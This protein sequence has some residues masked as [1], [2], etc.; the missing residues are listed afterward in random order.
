LVQAL[1]K[2][3]NF[4]KESSERGKSARDFIRYLDEMRKSGS[5]SEGVKLE[6]GGTLKVLFSQSALP[7]IT[8]LNLDLVDNEILLNALAIKNT[9]QPGRSRPYG[10]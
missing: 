5:L 10:T 3:E 9:G 1:K 4:K 8:S 6:E 7:H 2:L